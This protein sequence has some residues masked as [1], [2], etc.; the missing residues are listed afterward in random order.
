EAATNWYRQ[1]SVRAAELFLDELDRAVAQ[2]QTD[3]N[4]FPEYLFGTRRLLLR[5]FSYLV[6]FRLTTTAIEV[7]AIAHGRRR[8]GYWR[9]RVD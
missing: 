9:E 6:I 5:R 2:L 3:A 7:I 1:R 8:P 4:R